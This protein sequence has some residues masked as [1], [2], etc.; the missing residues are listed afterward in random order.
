MGGVCCLT[1]VTG[2]QQAQGNDNLPH[3]TGTVMHMLHTSATA[4]LILGVEVRG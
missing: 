1:A 2:G 3:N 4:G